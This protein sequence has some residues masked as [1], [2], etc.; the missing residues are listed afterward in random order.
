MLFVLHLLI[1]P[2]LNLRPSKD[3]TVFTDE[4]I[5]IL[6]RAYR[7]DKNARPNIR[8]FLAE[9]TQLPEERVRI[10]YQN[11]K[12]KERRDHED[13]WADLSKVSSSYDFG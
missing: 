2:S 1:D 9:L 12:A 7:Q 5:D 6:E 4:Q 11:R 13:E 3:R 10:W 8:Q